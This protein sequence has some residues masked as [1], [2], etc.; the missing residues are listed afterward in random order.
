MAD[1]T[2]IM[3][4][5]KGRSASICAAG[6]TSMEAIA[7]MESTSNTPEGGTP[8]G[9]RRRRPA[10]RSQSARIASGRSIRRRAAVAAA[11]NH[12][13]VKSH[14]N[15]E[16]KLADDSS[17]V[18][19]GFKRKH[20]T[21]RGTSVYHRKSTAFLEIP[22]QRSAY[23]GGGGSGGGGGG[24]E[25]DE[26]SYRLRSFSFTSKGKFLLHSGDKRIS[27]CETGDNVQLLGLSVL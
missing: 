4:R 9:Q 17:D 5:A 24:E 11:A 12:S 18:S 22:D 25:E 16:P 2:L 20:S 15:S 27:S 23:G 10:A 13:E 6:S 7:A 14:Y 26:D 8:T 21:R 1:D 3:S 19:P